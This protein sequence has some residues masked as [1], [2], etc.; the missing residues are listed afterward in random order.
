VAVESQNLPVK[1]GPMLHRKGFN[2]IK[3]E[4]IPIVN[5]SNTGNSFSTSMLKWLTKTAVKQAAVSRQESRDWLQQIR[6][7]AQQDAHFFCVNR[8]LF[9]AVK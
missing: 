9:T 5:T 2:A 6:Q 7:L 8:F 4:A 1:L 3:V